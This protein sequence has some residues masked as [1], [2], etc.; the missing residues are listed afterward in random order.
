MKKET[1]NIK[2]PAK[3][4][5]LFKTALTVVVLLVLVC[6]WLVFQIDAEKNA[7]GVE[8]S[9]VVVV[10]GDKPQPLEA[11]ELKNEEQVL[12]DMRETPDFEAVPETEEMPK[13]ADETVSNEQ[14][15]EPQILEVQEQSVEEDLQSA[16]ADKVWPNPPFVAIVV[17]DLGIN[18][19]R[20]K[21]ILSIKAPL[22]ASFL[23]YG[24]HLQDFYRESLRAGHEVMIHAPME[25]KTSSDTAPDE[26]K[27]SMNNEEIEKKFL[28]MLS[29][30]NGAGILF[31]NNHMGSLFTESKEKLDVVMKILKR[32]GLFFLDSRTTA[33]TV[34]EEVAAANGVEYLKR[35]VFLDNKNDVAH[36]QKQLERLENI[37]RKQGYAIAICHPK[38]QTV[39]VLKEWLE[40]LEQKDI[41]LVHLSEL[42]SIKRKKM[43]FDEKS[44]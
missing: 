44:S 27:V 6:A 1:V 17:D 15:E 40:S 2:E 32:E 24:E 12:L 18:V 43:L 41:K 14:L 11:A 35:D 25:P 33:N 19:P 30:F 39:R 20:T 3:S 26:L 36:I 4:S 13:N 42:M 23:T 9:S 5:L 8:K 37:A 34:G 10:L 38:S 29:K 21:D 28:E 31:I 7:F 16:P 22:T